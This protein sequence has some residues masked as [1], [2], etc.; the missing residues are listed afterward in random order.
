MKALIVYN[1]AGEIVFMMNKEDIEGDYYCVVAEIEEDKEVLSVDVSTGDVVTKDNDT[2][3][4]DIQ[5]YMN[6]ADDTTISKVEDT[7]LEVEAN[8]ILEGDV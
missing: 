6:S 1:K 2:R 7:I 3:V 8:K 5:S 4:Q